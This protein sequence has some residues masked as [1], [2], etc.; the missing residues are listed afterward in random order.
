MGAFVQGS[1]N[2]GGPDGAMRVPAASVE[3]Q[4]FEALGVAPLFGRAIQPENATPGRDRV[5]VLSHALWMDRFAGRRNIVGAPFRIDGVDYE[6]AGVMPAAFEFP[7]RASAAVWTPLSLHEYK[8]RGLKILTVIARTKPGVSLPAARHEMASVSRQL[9]E[10]YP[11]SGYAVLT[12]L[13]VETVGRTA[14]VL[15]V[16]G[17]AV[18]LV[19]LLACSNVAHM[20]LARANV[21]RHEFAVR[22]ALGASRGRVL[23]LLLI[24]GFMLA[25]A[26][27]AA[28]ASAC[29]PRCGCRARG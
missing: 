8:D 4:V 7:P 16:L 24:E 13:H 20:V 2:L 14:L 18:G 25:G 10:I 1:V 19:L 26:G 12:P 17:G 28:S 27:A 3:P 23:R 9:E 6:I 22:L 15:I 11:N 29:S 5:V 21:R